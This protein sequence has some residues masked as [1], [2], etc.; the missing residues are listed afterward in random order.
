MSNFIKNNL[1]FWI[2]RTAK[3]PKKFSLMNYTIF[4]FIS[5]KHA[6]NFYMLKTVWNNIL[7][8]NSNTPTAC[9]FFLITTSFNAVKQR[10]NFFLLRQSWKQTKLFVWLLYA[11]LIFNLCFFEMDLHKFCCE[12]LKKRKWLGFG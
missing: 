4:H 9:T 12:W 6:S 3:F 7:C 10:Q 8:W 1:A 11:N 2:C 5:N